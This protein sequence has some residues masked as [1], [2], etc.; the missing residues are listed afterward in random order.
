MSSNTKRSFLSVADYLEDEKLSTIKHEYI[1]G[2]VYA[3]AGG[4]RNHNILVFN[5]GSLIGSRLQ[6][7]CQ[8]YG[9]DM[10]IHVRRGEED[11]FY[12]PDVSVSCREEGGNEYYNEHPVLIIE[13][14]SPSTERNDKYE[15]F[16]AYRSL[17]SLQEYVLVYQDI[18]E[19]WVFSRTH[20]WEKTI[21]NEG[22]IRLA[23]VGV[24]LTVDDVYRNVRLE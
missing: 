5:L 7:P 13:V 15:K 22:D 8:G 20:Q 1:A 2:D 3:T 10:K 14:L 24:T 6:P 12:Y 23:S 9:S 17:D 16:L 4:S 18:R 19:I 11:I 21:H